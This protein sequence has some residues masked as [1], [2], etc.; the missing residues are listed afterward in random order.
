[1]VPRPRLEIAELL[2]LHLIELGI[3]LDDV[4]VGVVVIGRDVVARPV[5][6]RSPDDRNRLL[7]EQLAGVL[8][9]G[10]VL[11]LERDVVHLRLLAGEEVHRV[12][13]RAAAQKREE[14]LHPVGNPEAEHLRIEFGDLPGVVDDEGDVAELERSNADHLM[15]MAEIVPVREQLDDRFLSDP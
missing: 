14:V 12:M 3:E 1:M 2:V 4:V 9:V 13:V 5:P 15:M 6:Q 10:E 7:A 11:H 8:D